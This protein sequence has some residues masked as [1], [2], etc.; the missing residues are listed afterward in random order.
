MATQPSFTWS[1]GSS[2]LGTLSASGLFT[3]AQSASGSGT[4]QATAGG[5]TGRA[6]VTVSTSGAVLFSD[7]FESGG[8]KWTVTSG[9]YDYSLVHDFGSTRLLVYNNGSTISRVVAGQ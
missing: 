4:V 7:N 8:S 2:A 6:M 5:L 1:L 3:A 9:Y